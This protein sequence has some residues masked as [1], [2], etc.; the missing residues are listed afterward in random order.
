[1]HLPAGKGEPG[2]VGKNQVKG[3]VKQAEGAK[4]VHNST[5]GKAGLT[6]A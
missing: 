1:M 3:G 5:V 6:T 4:G 2:E